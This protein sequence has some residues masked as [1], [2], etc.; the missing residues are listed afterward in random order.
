[1]LVWLGLWQAAAMLLHTR[2]I[3]VSPA[4]V[5][6]RL[7]MLVTETDFWQTILWSGLRIVGGF[8][9]A[10]AAGM[11]LGAAAGR[12]RSVRQLL[13]PAVL[14]AKSVPVVSFIILALFLLPSGYLTFLIVFLMV[15]PIVYTNVLEGIRSMDKDLKEMALLFRVPLLRRVRAVYLPQVYPYLRSACGVGAGLAWKAGTAAEVIGLPGGSVGERLYEAKIYLETADLFA[16]TVVIILLSLAGEKLLLA[17][18][19]SAVRRL[20]R[21]G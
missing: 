7:G 21:I 5:L 3:L 10:A 18:L 8:I 4:E 17:L 16:W 1:M 12:L 14:A 9:A 11:L 20:E 6:V 19:K 2:L 15:F 13:A